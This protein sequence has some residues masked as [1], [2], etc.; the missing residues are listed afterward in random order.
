M[1]EILNENDGLKGE[2]S[3]ENSQES[4]KNDTKNSQENEQNDILNEQENV[5][6]NTLLS[7]FDKKERKRARRKE[8]AKFLTLAILVLALAYYVGETLF[9]ASSYDTMRS[10]SI[11]KRE[12][13]QRIEYYKAQNAE[14]QKRY[15]EL[16]G[17]YPNEK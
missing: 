6:E 5:G 11:T 14:L 3:Q 10:L 13:E 15:F 17:L 7:E 8:V 12:L 4:R 1:S 16:K 2:N 9:G